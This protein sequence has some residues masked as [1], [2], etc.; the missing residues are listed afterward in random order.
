MRK[1]FLL[2][3]SKGSRIILIVRI[4]Q[5]DF[6]EAVYKNLKQDVS[7]LWPGMLSKY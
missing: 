7:Y 1:F 2:N 3:S 4:Y 5:N 6:S